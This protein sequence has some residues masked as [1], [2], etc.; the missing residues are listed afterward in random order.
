MSKTL[1]ESAKPNSLRWLDQAAQDLTEIQATV[2]SRVVNARR[3]G[4]SWAEIGKALGMT[5]QAAQQRYAAYCRVTEALT[6][7]DEKGPS[8]TPSIIVDAPVPAKKAPSRKVAT[9]APA[10]RYVAANRAEYSIVDSPF[11]WS[12]T[13]PEG[14]QP[15]TGKGP[16]ACPTCGDTNHKG[17]T[18]HHVQ[19]NADCVPTKY[20]PAYIAKFM[21]LV[22]NATQEGTK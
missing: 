9:K 15:G 13:V 6:Q 10:K 17:A 21:R 2:R 12:V 19:F 11:G 14:A 5:K 4:A 1:T 22:H 8:V 18:N 3:C 7:D 16:H 20:D